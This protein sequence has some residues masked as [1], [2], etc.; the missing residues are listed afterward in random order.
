MWFG[1]VRYPEK[2]GLAKKIVKNEESFP[3]VEAHT[4]VTQALCNKKARPGLPRS[5][6]AFYDYSAKVPRRGEYRFSKTTRL[7]SRKKP[8]NDLSAASR[9]TE[10][11]EIDGFVAKH[12]AILQ[13][14]KCHRIKSDFA[15]ALWTQYLKIIYP[16]AETRFPFL[17]FFHNKR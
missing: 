15:A 10:L 2:E 1:A 12:F 5:G 13:R 9:A 17:C 11:R 16:P 6:W 3:S 8:S 4:T 14:E 7:F